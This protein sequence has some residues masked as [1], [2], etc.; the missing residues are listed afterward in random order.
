MRKG[1]ALATA[2]TAAVLYAPDVEAKEQYIVKED[3]TTK[4]HKRPRVENTTERCA[5]DTTSFRLCGKYGASVVF[6]WDWEQE[7]YKLTEATKY[8]KIRLDF[9]LKQSLDLEGEFFADRLYSNETFVTIEPFKMLYTFQLTRWYYNQRLCGAI[10][11]AIDDFI[12]E[13]IMRQRFLEASKNILESPWS[14]E[15]W[16]SPWALW[17]DDFGLS[18]YAPI[19]VKKKEIQ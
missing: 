8:Y 19:T 6:G 12:L 18:D 15:N 3:I 11:Y 10:Y 9:Y 2:V 17:I 16:D 14:L 1:F 4:E 5:Y 7:F 13:V